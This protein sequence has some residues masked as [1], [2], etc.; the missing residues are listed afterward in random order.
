MADADTCRQ[1]HTLLIT[2]IAYPFMHELICDLGS[3]LMTMLTCDHVQHQVNSSGPAAT[4][5]AFTINLK[6]F[7]C[8]LNVR[9]NLRKCCQIFPMN[10]APVAIQQPSLCQD[11]S[12][13]ADGPDIHFGRRHATQPRHQR[14]DISRLHIN[15]CAY[16]NRLN[17]L[18]AFQI[19]VDAYKYLITSAYSFTI[20]AGEVPTI[21]LFTSHTIGQAQWLNGTG[22]GHHR[23]AL[24]RHKADFNRQIVCGRTKH[25]RA[26]L[27]RIHFHPSQRMTW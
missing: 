1:R 6:Q 3:N 7:G 23:K 11:I 2:L 19:T 9:K 26:P 5:D 4:G 17:M 14:R 13:R 27:D 20:L 24:T 15:A 22:K 12:A 16:E 8:D 21:Q 18:N 10:R 25:W